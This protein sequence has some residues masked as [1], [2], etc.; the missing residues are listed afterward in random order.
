MNFQRQFCRSLSALCFVSLTSAFD[1][2]VNLCPA[3]RPPMHEQNIMPH[4]NLLRILSRH[5][6][7]TLS[8]L[9]NI[10]YFIFL[11]RVLPQSHVRKGNP[12]SL[13]R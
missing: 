6:A 4:L 8:L 2:K 13:I 9:C 7:K 3:L 12:H 1:W 11:T 5:V 10:Q